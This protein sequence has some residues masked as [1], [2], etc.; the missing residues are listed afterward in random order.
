MEFDYS[1]MGLRIVSRR[2]R[3]GIKQN[4]L[5]EQIN[6]S[7]NYLSGIERGKENPSLEVVIKICNALQVTPD[8]LLLGNLHANNVPQN[9]F[10]SLR[11]CS[12]EDIELIS[13]FIQLLIN[14]GEEQQKRGNY[15]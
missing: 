9:I 5:A 14:R 10:E 12:E 7:N 13:Q 3:L 2:K 4:E 11:L 6:I 15:I 1:T 8:Y